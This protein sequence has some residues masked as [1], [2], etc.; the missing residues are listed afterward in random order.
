MNLA[1]VVFDVS[2][3]FGLRMGAAGVGLGTSGAEWVALATGV[4]VVTR[5][6]GAN[7]VAPRVTV[8]VTPATAEPTLT[9]GLLQINTDAS[10]NF[11]A[12]SINV[13][14]SATSGLN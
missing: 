2:L 13:I 6:A 11:S 1:N 7:P 12:N 4:L 14:G 8:A 5:I 3:V 9:G 10:L